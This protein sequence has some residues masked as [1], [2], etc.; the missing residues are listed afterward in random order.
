MPRHRIWI[1]AP[2]A[3]RLGRPRVSHA[4][5]PDGW[6]SL[7]EEEPPRRAAWLFFGLCA[8]RL[9]LFR[10]LPAAKAAATKAAAAAV[11][12]QAAAVAAVASEAAAAAT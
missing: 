11:A 9:S 7:G 3:G 12:A 5:E 4:A 6:V 2:F 10:E 1:E 8:R